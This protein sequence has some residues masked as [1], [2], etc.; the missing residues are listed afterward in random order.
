[1]NNFEKLKNENSRLMDA[2]EKKKLTEQPWIKIE[3]SKE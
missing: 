2:I 3:K 1:M